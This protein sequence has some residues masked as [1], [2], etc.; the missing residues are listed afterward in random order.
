MNRIHFIRHLISYA[1]LSFPTDFHCNKIT[2]LC[3]TTGLAYCEFDDPIAIMSSFMEAN[4]QSICYL[5]HYIHAIYTLSGHAIY[6][7]SNMY[8]IYVA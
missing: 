5:I 3:Y 2:E 7:L 4:S 8:A 6:M 1:G